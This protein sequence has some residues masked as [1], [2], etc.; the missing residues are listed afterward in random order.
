MPCSLYIH[1]AR[2]QWVCAWNL[3]LT[4][5]D[6]G[7]R[8]QDSVQISAV[9]SKSPGLSSCGDNQGWRQHRSVETLP[10]SS[11]RDKGMIHTLVLM[12]PCQDNTTISGLLG[13]FQQPVCVRIDLKGEL[14]KSG[15]FFAILLTFHL[16]PLAMCMCFP[17]DQIQGAFYV[18]C[19]YLCS[20][21]CHKKFKCSSFEDHFVDMNTALHTIHLTYDSLLSDMF[22]REF[23]FKTVGSM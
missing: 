17:W 21:I 22:W 4:Q 13:S 1:S 16:L 23:G 5:L 19:V 9:I 3:P 7:Q 15:C 6:R 11:L 12:A 8:S 2:G 14:C 18:P 20:R 10:V